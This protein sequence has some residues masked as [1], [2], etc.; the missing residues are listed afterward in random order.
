LIELFKTPNLTTMKGYRR[1]PARSAGILQEATILIAL[2][3][4]ELGSAGHLTDRRRANGSESTDAHRDEQREDHGFH[5]QSIK[6]PPVVV[7]KQPGV[8]N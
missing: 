5:G 1:S 7:K 8:S 2:A 4:E 6:K 3:T